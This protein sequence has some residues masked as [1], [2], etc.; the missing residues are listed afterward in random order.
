ME[1]ELPVDPGLADRTRIVVELSKKLLSYFEWRDAVAVAVGIL[2]EV[3]RVEGRAT[4]EWLTSTVG[5]SWVATQS[6]HMV[7]D[8]EGREIWARERARQRGGR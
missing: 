2:I 6:E 7:S 3:V 4:K 5:A 1:H 8:A